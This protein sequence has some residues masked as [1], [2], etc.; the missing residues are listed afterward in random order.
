MR[1]DQIQR[2]LVF[3]PVFINVRSPMDTVVLI[4][5]W[6]AGLFLLLCC[7]VFPGIMRSKWSAVEA[8]LPPVRVVTRI[9]WVLFGLVMLL[10]AVMLLTKWWWLVW[11]GA[12][13]VLAASLMMAAVYFR[14]RR[15]AGALQSLMNYLERHKARADEVKDFIEKNTALFVRRYQ[16]EPSIEE[17]LEGF[18]AACELVTGEKAP[19]VRLPPNLL[20]KELS[21]ILNVKPRDSVWAKFGRPL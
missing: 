14:S 3:L 17:E 15:M 19:C 7:C 20:P 2:F 5:R 4:L 16:R 10:L 11:W 18:W 9:C 8:D 21:V 12:G 13:L 6:I 1:Q